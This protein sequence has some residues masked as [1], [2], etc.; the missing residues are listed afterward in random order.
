MKAISQL[1]LRMAREN[2]AWGYRRIQGAL[3]IVGH[4]VAHNTVKKILRDNGIDPAPERSKQTSWSQ[5]LR[6]HWDILGGSDFFTVEVWTP[7]GLVTFYVLFVLELRT[8][9]VRIVGWTPHPNRVFMH[10]AALDLVEIDRPFPA[11]Q[12][13]ILDRDGKY[14]CEFVDVLGEHDI[15]V[16]RTPARSPNCNAHA[17]RFVRSIKR[18]C[19]DRVVLIGE[20]SLRRTLR[21]YERHYN[22]ER[23]HQGI[24]NRL[25]NGEKRASTAGSVRC[26]PRLGGLL[27]FY[28]RAS[29]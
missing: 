24:G 5:F 27:R 26:R 10:Q 13:I 12:R 1:T 14:S 6:T 15:E 2:P 20:R 4:R 29:A 28:R 25:I 22:A 18:E 7:K 21:Q 23:T 11:M 8:R 9:A 19:L 17:E 3:D 16:T